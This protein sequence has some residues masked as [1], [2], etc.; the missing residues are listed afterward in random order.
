MEPIT[1]INQ[2][3]SAEMGLKE[4][5]VEHVVGLLEGGATIPFISRYRKEMTGSLDEVILTQI[6]DRLEQLHEVE[7]RRAYILKTIEEQGKLNP[8]LKKSLKEAETMAALEDLYL[9]YKPKR[10]TRAT[11]AREKGLEPLA[12]LIYDQ[13]DMNLEELAGKFINP[14]KEVQDVEE[15]LQGARD[16]MAEWIA[17]DVRV[18][19]MLRNL[20]YREGILSCKNIKGKEMEGIK[21]KDYFDF[22]EPVKKIPSHRMLAMRRG[23]KESFLSIDIQPDEGTALRGMEKL[24]ITARN[25]S[26]EQVETAIQDGYKRLLKPS[27]ETE[28]RMQTKKEADIEA[29]TVFVDNLRQ[30]LLAPPLGQKRVLAI[31]P[32]FRT[33]CKVV[34]L[35]E[36]GKLL[37]HTAIFPNEPQNQVIE[38]AAAVK[39]Q[40][41]SFGIQAIA[42]GNGTASRETE[43]FV[44]S[45]G[46]PPE[47][48]IV[49]VNESGASIYSASEVA[50]EE[51]P[52][53]DVTVRGAVSIG[54]RL[55]DPL[56]E[57]VKIEPKSIGVGQYQHDV[58]QTALKKSLDDVVVSC[59]NAV[60]VELN[61]ASKQILSYVSGLGPQLA[62]NIVQFRNENGPFHSRES[63]KK[64]P[65]MGEKVFEQCAGFLRIRNGINPLDG[66]AVHP[67]RYALVEKMAFDM[68][69][70]IR[71]LL[72]DAER[73]NRIRIADYVTEE[74][75]LPT[76]QDIMEEMNKPGRDPRQ[77]YEIFEFSEEVK[78]I[79]DLKT[80]MVLPGIITNITK[81]GAFVDIGV[82]QDGLIHISQMSDQYV[83]DPA[84]VVKINQRVKVTVTEVDVDRKRISLSM[85]S[86]Q[87][88]PPKKPAT[89]SGGK[90]AKGS[91]PLPGAKP[92]SAEKPGKETLQGD[93]K[94]K[95]E[96][97]KGKFR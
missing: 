64:V 72:S 79:H 39:K 36:Q 68:G 35:D 32:G 5:Q 42:I 10:R 24:L 65:R 97:L 33:G 15:A 80:G 28:I 25:S 30:L 77:T 22:S 29:I 53:K 16:I 34:C 7:K 71:D 18:R 62:S 52:D 78:D 63:L 43:S 46:L 93:M 20:F 88:S 90:S 1:S 51:F 96:A 9:P 17:E 45:L 87:S 61:T 59:V 3:I 40:V 83:S 2:K 44:R 84:Q 75:G 19:D 81:F 12:K 38:S 26:A 95:L 50:R 74:A 4:W 23:E 94:S 91:K 60:G 6:R 69:C 47:I 8:E 55:M 11:V 48:T 37:Y 31:D 76:L 92:P 86:E 73:R 85:K 57:L 21:Y 66:S 82:H 13:K 56:A 58:D 67:E 70:T 54:R 27:M 14:E 49:M 89:G 41:D